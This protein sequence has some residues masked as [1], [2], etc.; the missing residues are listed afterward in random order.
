MLKITEI[1]VT[2]KRGRPNY[3]SQGAEVR[4][5]VENPDDSLDVSETIIYITKTIEEA[6]NRK[7][8]PPSEVKAVTVVK[9]PVS[10][11]AESQPQAPK[12]RGRPAKTVEVPAAETS[13]APKS[14]EDESA[15]FFDEEPA[16]DEAQ[17]IPSGEPVD[18]AFNW[19]E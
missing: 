12:R 14:A 15:A 16:D 11:P 10:Q 4:C 6:W 3:G 8:N 9:Q 13:K 19:D 17:N 18:D 2:H 7:E 1:V 5:V